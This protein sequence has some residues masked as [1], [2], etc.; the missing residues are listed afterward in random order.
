MRLRQHDAAGKAAA[1]ELVKGDAD[2]GQAGGLDHRDAFRLE[3][4][5]V[6]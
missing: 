4:L 3:A 6:Q 2:R 1:V 5:A